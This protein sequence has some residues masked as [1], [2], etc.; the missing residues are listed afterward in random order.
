MM[1]K[2]MTQRQV[3]VRE[4]EKYM[5]KVESQSGDTSAGQREVREK[6]LKENISRK[7]IT[8]IISVTDSKV[9]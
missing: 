6:K 9:K 3:G 5:E 8:R 1:Y 2:S 7:I 4:G